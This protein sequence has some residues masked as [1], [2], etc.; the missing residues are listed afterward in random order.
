M[1]NDNKI[2]NM[3]HQDITYQII[4]SA[5]EVHRFLGPGLLES[6]YRECLHYELRAK[7]FF[8]EKEKMLPIVYKE[9][10]LSNAYRIDLL[11]NNEVV[12]ELK[13]VEALADVHIAQVLTYLKMGGFPLGLIFNFYTKDL[14]QGI[15]RIFH[16]P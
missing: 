5:F 1:Q 16:T 15:K 7:G 8:V 4:G 2:L 14:K 12:L 11:V 10:N 3:G 9:I 6:T 13:C